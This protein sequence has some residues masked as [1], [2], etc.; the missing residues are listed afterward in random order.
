MKRCTQCSVLF[1]SADWRCPA[2]GF[3][4]P[5]T[6]GFPA[7]APQLAGAG[8]GFRS[9]YFPQLATLES[10]HFWFE[11]RNRLIVWS[12]QRYFSHLCNFMEIG[13]GTGFV[14]SAIADTF[15]DARLTG[16][17][18]FSAALPFAAERLPTGD[19]VQMDARALPYFEHFDVIGAFDVLEHI[20]EDEQALKAIHRALKPNGGLLVTVP[21]HRW[22]WSVQDEL[23]SHVR[24]YTAAELRLKVAAAGFTTVYD[25]SFV[26]LLLPMMWLSRRRERGVLAKDDPLFE[27]RIGRGA[28]RLLSTIMAFEWHLI[29]FGI[30][31]PFGGSFL[32]VARRG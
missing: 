4:P 14:L 7:L 22:L 5:I 10:G 13:C 2:C 32:L 27:L 9:E 30:R 23:G 11:S 17:E 26:S 19:F 29:R 31:F 3:Q 18:L 25:T 21:Q 1:D 24:R 20:P 8:Q 6:T 28:N 12:L 15:P 16:S